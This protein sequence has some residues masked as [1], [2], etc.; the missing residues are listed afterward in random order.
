VQAVRRNSFVLL[1]D[2]PTKRN[3]KT[4]PLCPGTTEIGL[5]SRPQK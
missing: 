2:G 1:A 3:G 4:M 5:N